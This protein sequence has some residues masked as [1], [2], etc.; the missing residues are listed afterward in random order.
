M[1]MDQVYKKSKDFVQREIAGEFILIPLKPQLNEAKSLY[2]LNETGAAL[3][4]RIDG[5][6]SA[7]AIMD[8]F[9]Q[10]FD[11]PGEQ[12]EKDFH[13]LIEDLLSIRAIEETLTEG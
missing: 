9:A 13:A 7:Q 8:D 4:R 1:R 11:V 2:V 12:L 5:Q 6:C 3:W 10:E